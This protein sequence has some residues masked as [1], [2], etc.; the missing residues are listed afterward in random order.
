MLICQSKIRQICKDY[1]K[2]ISGST[3]ESLN[4]KVYALVEMAIKAT[5]GAKRVLPRDV[6]TIGL[7]YNLSTQETPLGSRR[8]SR[9]GGR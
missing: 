1:G 3:F 5:G 2:Q 7:K 4:S 6:N 8:V 9:K